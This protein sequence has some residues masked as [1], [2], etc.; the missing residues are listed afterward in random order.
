MNYTKIKKPILYI[1][2]Y[3]IGL[4]CFIYNYLDSIDATNFES[5]AFWLDAAFL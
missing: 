2:N 5:L 4:K 3:N 1:Y